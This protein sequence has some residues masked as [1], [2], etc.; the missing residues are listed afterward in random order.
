VVW[1]LIRIRCADIISMKLFDWS[2]WFGTLTHDQVSPIKI[3]LYGPLNFL[4]SLVSENRYLLAVVP[5]FFGRSVEEM[6]LGCTNAVQSSY[7]SRAIIHIGGIFM[8]HFKFSVEFRIQLTIQYANDNYTWERPKCEPNI[9]TTSTNAI[10][11]EQTLVP[12]Q[13]IL[14][15]LHSKKP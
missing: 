3:F 9:G 15:A 14:Q 11:M 2:R 1:I 8:V 6:K 5:G 4:R 7:Y 12:R 10:K 13:Q